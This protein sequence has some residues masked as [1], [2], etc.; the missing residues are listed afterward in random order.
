MTLVKLD[1]DKWN[2]QDGAVTLNEGCHDDGRLAKFRHNLTPNQD[3]IGVHRFRDSI[4]DAH[5]LVT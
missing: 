5:W 1:F 2:L 3:K 4:D